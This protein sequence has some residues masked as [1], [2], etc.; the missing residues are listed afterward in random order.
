[1]S[2]LISFVNQVFTPE[3]SLG[4]YDEQN[5]ELRWVVPYG[6][7]MNA[8]GA[9]GI[10]LTDDSIYVCCQQSGLIRLDHGFRLEGSYEFKKVADPHSMV[11]HGGC[12]YIVSS[13]TDE[14]YR[15]TLDSGGQV[16]CEELFWRNPEAGGEGKDQTHLNSIAV[17]PGGDFYVTCFGE[18]DP[19]GR[20]NTFGGKLIN[21]T[22]GEVVM[23]N[24]R[25]PHTAYYYSGTGR[26]LLCESL[27]G[28]LL[29]ED[30]FESRL[31]GYTRGVCETQNDLI[32]ASS[33]RRMISKS[34][35]VLV[36]RYGDFEREDEKN[37]FLHFIDKKTMKPSRK[38]RFS[39]YGKEIF[40]IVR[41]DPEK[42]NPPGRLPDAKVARIDSF[43]KNLL[44]LV[45]KIDRL[46]EE[47]QSHISQ[48]GRL[49][50][51]IEKLNAQIGEIYNS[52]SWKVGRR[53]TRLF[54]WMKA[55]SRGDE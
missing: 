22:S 11:Y 46:G 51:E 30:G 53:I 49:E 39:C 4:Y 13:G 17:T 18:K 54:S 7:N 31:G 33:A 25:N 52:S 20:M 23:D 8:Q 48:R 37:S 15:L 50:K 28:K 38:V 9:T 12:L 32:V 21:I 16:S 1:M 35:G 42:T 45:S 41:L 6:A 26:I 44:G 24:L 3:L 2:L 10:A 40:D 29:G 47:K 36:G 34:K 43:E 5:D 19:G 55:S 27:T 14:V